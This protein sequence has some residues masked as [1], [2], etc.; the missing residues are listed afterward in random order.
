[1]ANH[2]ATAIYQKIVLKRKPWTK[3]KRMKTAQKDE[4]SITVLIIVQLL[5]FPITAQA[6]LI[7]EISGSPFATEGAPLPHFVKNTFE[8]FI[9]VDPRE[10]VW[11]AYTANGKLIRWGVATAGADRCTDSGLPCRTKIGNFRIYL[12]GNNNCSSYK[13]DNAPMPYCMY[14]N[15]SQAL[16]GSSEIEFANRSHGCVRIHVEDA[17]WLRYHFVE[18]PSLANNYRG[19][20]IIIRPY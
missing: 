7:T 8:K 9:L 18:K 19:T 6:H 11:G 15:G 20:K 17:K 14:F 4:T 5:L 13:Y 3:E 10:H 12:L 16:H 1:M 2:L